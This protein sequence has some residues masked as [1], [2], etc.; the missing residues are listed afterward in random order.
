[1]ALDGEMVDA[2]TIRV[3]EARDAAAMA[4]IYAPIVRDTWISFETEPPSAAEMAQRVEK[5]LATLP[6]LVVVRGDEVLGY[7]YASP[8]SDRGAYRWSVHTTVYLHENARGQG[9]GTKL[10]HALFDVLRRLGIKTAFAGI[11]LPNAASI[12]LHESVG[13]R[14]LGVYEDVGFKLGAWRSVGWWRLPLAER[15]PDPAEPLAFARLRGD[16]RL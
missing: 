6:W 2:A 5:V 14:P 9:L 12:G 13:F 3:A 15:D 4:A 7:A 16:L 11:A 1:M 10:Y 8:H